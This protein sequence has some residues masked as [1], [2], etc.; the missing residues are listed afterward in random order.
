MDGEGEDIGRKSRGKQFSI[1]K[2]KAAAQQVKGDEVEEVE[3]EEEKR[4]KQEGKST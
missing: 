4:S 3:E 2:G 1:R